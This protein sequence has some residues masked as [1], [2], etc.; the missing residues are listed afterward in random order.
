M[1]DR[2]TNHN[3]ILVSQTCIEIS[4]SSMICS[5]LMARYLRIFSQQYRFKINKNGFCQHAINRTTIGNS[6]VKIRRTDCYERC[7]ER[8]RTTNHIIIQEAG[9]TTIPSKC[10]R[11]IPSR[12]VCSWTGTILIGNHLDFI[13]SISYSSVMWNR[14]SYKKNVV[15]IYIY[16]H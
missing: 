3:S 2:I 4:F 13:D 12:K 6:L 5:F 10:R 14:V 8:D 7:Y 9:I 16:D 15:F 11:T 1:N